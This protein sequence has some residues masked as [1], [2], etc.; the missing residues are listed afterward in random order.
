M[1]RTAAPKLGAYAGLAALGL[2]ASLVLGRP[3]LAVLAAPF[4]LLLFT[5]LA[6]AR[7][8]QFLVSLAL[9][10][11]RAV[12][13]DEFLI[14]I[15]LEARTPVERLELHIPLRDG[16]EIVDGASPLTLHLDYGEERTVE[17]RVRCKRWGAYVVGELTLRA[18]D[19]LD[20]DRKS[21]RL[22]S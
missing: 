8:P 4:A 21:T 14:T 7:E 19:R 1:K 5:G 20:L 9:D 10:R 22:N 11:D 13:G 2:L 6:A 15:D 17:L 12:E 18:H 3:E 16:L